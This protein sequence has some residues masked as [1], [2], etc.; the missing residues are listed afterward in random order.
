[1][2]SYIY[3]NVKFNLI[4][5]TFHGHEKTH[6]NLFFYIHVVDRKKEQ[7]SFKMEAIIRKHG[8]ELL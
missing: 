1:M 8:R 7:G 2:F 4:Y 6:V 3:V 5:Y